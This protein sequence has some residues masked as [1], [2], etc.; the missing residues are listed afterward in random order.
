VTGEPLDA[1]V[2]GA[3][4]TIEQF[5]TKAGSDAM[6]HVQTY[7]NTLIRTPNRVAWVTENSFVFSNDHSNKVGFVSLL[8]QQLEH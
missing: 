5:Q 8:L 4:S 2:V 1:T 6:Q 7:V 3:N